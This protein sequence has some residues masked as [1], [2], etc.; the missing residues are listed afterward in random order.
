MAVL[1]QLRTLGWRSVWSDVPRSPVIWLVLAA[2]YMAGP[3][4][5]WVIFRR[6]W[7][8]PA[9]GIFPLL[10]KL[11]GNELLPINYVGEV[12]FY[13]WAR[14][15]V[16][17]DASPFGAVK[18]VAILS[19]LAGNVVTVIMLALTWPLIMNLGLG[20]NSFYLFGSIAFV[21]VTS[22]AIVFFRKG[23][24]SLPLPELW[25]IFAVH[26]ARIVANTGLQALAWHLIQPEV[27]LGPWLLFATVRLLVARLPFIPNK[28]ITFA[29]IA[30]LLAVQQVQTGPMLTMISLLIVATHVALYIAMM[31]LD[32][33]QKEK[34]A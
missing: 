30:T 23:L 15:H 13:D 20:D 28:D 24:L 6:L 10:K 14:R 1:L 33:I 18:D 4:A 5:D 17:I 9:S 3:F 26:C 31:V 7:G 2:S 29:G 21:L 34:N 8:I 19:A 25:F 32:L 12:Y 27:P 16:K 11:I 22:I